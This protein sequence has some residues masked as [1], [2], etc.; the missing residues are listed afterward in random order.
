MKAIFLAVFC[1]ASCKAFAQ[2]SRFSTQVEYTLN[3]ASTTESVPASASSLYLPGQQFVLRS[4]YRFD[5]H[6]SGTIGLGYMNTRSYY[7]IQVEGPDELFRITSRLTHHYLMIPIGVKFNFGHF[8]LNPEFAAA[9]NISNTSRDQ[10][11]YGSTSHFEIIKNRSTDNLNFN[12]VQS[13][14]FPVFLGI[15]QEIPLESVTLTLGMKG[16]Y[17]LSKTGD[18]AVVSNH[19]FGFGVSAGVSF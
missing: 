6:I 16:Y 14:A 9:R 10:F 12:Q 13:W 18:R 3:F 19:A 7:D 8:Y 5:N 17:M 11:Y 1:F 4:A 2:E 15:G